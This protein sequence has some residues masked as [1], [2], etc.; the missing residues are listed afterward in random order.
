MAK[1]S[2][3]LLQELLDKL[4]ERAMPKGLFLYGKVMFSTRIA[5][6]VV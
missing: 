2:L 4:I 1:D 3:Y 6:V 5:V